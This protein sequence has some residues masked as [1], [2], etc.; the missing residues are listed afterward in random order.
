MEPDEG[1]DAGADPV[2]RKIV[3]VEDSPAPEA[4]LERLMASIGQQS[5][6]LSCEFS[7][8]TSWSVEMGLLSSRAATL[9]PML[10]TM[11]DR[12]VNLESELAESFRLRQSADRRVAELT[13]EI[14]HFRPLAMRLED[15]LRVETTRH[16]RAQ[17][18]LNSLEEQFAKIQGE[19]NEAVQKLASAEALVARMREEGHMHKQK[20]LEHNMTIQSLMREVAR[21]KSAVAVAVADVELS[22]NEIVSLT[23]RLS[24]E[25]EAAGRAIAD[26][27]TAELHEGRLNRDL[28]LRLNEAE[29]REKTLAETVA[30][31]NKQIYEFEIQRSGIDSKIDFLTRMNERLRDDLRRHVDHTALLE[32]ANRQLLE[33]LSQGGLNEPSGE[34]FPDSES[35]KTGAT[36]KLRAV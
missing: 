25:K 4:E 12:K 32:S 29:A 26:M 34:E 11:L 21:L 18:S 7:R 2:E 27:A 8:L 14:E 5:I 35:L 33:S 6:D 20:A 24:L 15:E 31:K 1:Y 9:E 3:E 28:Q 22:G 13:T 10:K 19:T 23:E 30:A 36:T 17:S 16:H